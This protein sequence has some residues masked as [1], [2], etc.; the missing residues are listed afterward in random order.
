VVVTSVV[1]ALLI[2]AYRFLCM[3][4]N[5]RRDKSGIAEGFDNA[6]DDDLTD[7]KVCPALSLF[8]TIKQNADQICRTPSSVIF[9]SHVLLES[10]VWW[11]CKCGDV[12]S[13][14]EPESCTYSLFN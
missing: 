7:L 11:E 4:D 1:A 5:K 6:Y 3:W 8:M 10:R 9:C 14:G 13:R 12:I 2:I